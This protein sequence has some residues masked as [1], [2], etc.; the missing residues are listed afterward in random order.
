MDPDIIL[1]I[2]LEWVEDE[3]A[4]DLEIGDEDVIDFDLDFVDTGQDENLQEKTHITPT[5]ES[6][7]ILPDAGY[8]GL[9]AVQIDPIPSCYGL[10]TWDGSTLTIT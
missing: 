3:I 9:S 8:T 7:I 1:D 5:Q 4:F 2:E 10:V 6:Q